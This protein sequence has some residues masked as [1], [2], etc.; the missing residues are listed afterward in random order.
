[1]Q[2]YSFG[3]GVANE[4]S[5]KFFRRVGNISLDRYHFHWKREVL[6][7]PLVNRSQVDA[8]TDAL[9]PLCST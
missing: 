5:R 2:K 9:R 6:L 4:Y 1:M 3:K 8:L 7:F